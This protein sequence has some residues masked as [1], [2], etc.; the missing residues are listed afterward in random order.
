MSKQNMKEDIKSMNNTATDC[1]LSPTPLVT[2]AIPFKH[3]MLAVTVIITHSKV[4]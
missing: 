2:V 1:P 4:I 3:S